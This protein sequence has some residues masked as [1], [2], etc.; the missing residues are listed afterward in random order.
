MAAKLNDS[1]VAA[2]LS[3]TDKLHRMDKEVQV[4]RQEKEELAA[5][6]NGTEYLNQFLTGKVRD[7]ENKL[8]RSRDDEV[9][10]VQQIA[11]DQE[12]I[13]FLDSRVQELE[14][15]T[16][17]L[18]KEKSECETELSTTKVQTSKKITMLSDMLKYEREKLKD[19]E[20]EWKATKKVLVK[21]V[22]SCRAQILAL[23]AE[24]DGLREQ[25]EM[26]KR[27]IVSTGKSPSN[28]PR[29]ESAASSGT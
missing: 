11:S 1:E 5:K 3:M 14:R 24:R 22:K 8:A 2:I 25:N 10:V 20:G 29:G 26:L 6:L 19:E 16:K 23:Q 7:V 4:L 28:R 18:T 12:V 27:A 21:E 13:A 17:T 9:K 15:Q